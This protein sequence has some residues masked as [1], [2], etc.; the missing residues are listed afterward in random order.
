MLS[1]KNSRKNSSRNNSGS[2][3]N[4]LNAPRRLASLQSDTPFAENELSVQSTLEDFI[5]F[6]RQVVHPAFKLD[7]AVSDNDKKVVNSFDTMANE[8]LTCLH[9]MEE[10][11][12]AFTKWKNDF[13]RQSVPSNMYA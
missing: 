5:E 13:L 2:S 7:I 6:Q 12:E 4:K 10:S 11:L 8:V 1:R 9:E 3:L